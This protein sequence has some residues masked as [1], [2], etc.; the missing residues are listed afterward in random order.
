MGSRGRLLLFLTTVLYLVLTP[1]A[2]PL[3]VDPNPGPLAPLPA[4]GN[5]Q[6]V[7]NVNEFVTV[8][9]PSRVLQRPG[10]GGQ[11]NIRYS[12]NAIRSTSNDVLRSIPVPANDLRAALQAAVNDGAKHSPSEMQTSFVSSAN[13]LSVIMNTYEARSDRPPFNWQD[14]SSV[15][16]VLLKSSPGGAS[17]ANSFV[18]VVV[19]PEGKSIVDFA[20][21]PT[22]V[23]VHSKG[24][25]S[26][27]A[28]APP[29]KY[30]E[31]SLDTPSKLQNRATYL[32]H[33]TAL[34]LEYD[35]GSHG[36]NGLVLRMLIIY[37]MD[38]VLLDVPD[39]TYTTVIASPLGPVQPNEGHV[40]FS[41]RAVN[42]QRISRQDALTIT[43]AIGAVV[44]TYVQWNR[45]PGTPYRSIVGRVLNNDGIGIAYWSVGEP[46]GSV[47]ECGTVIVAQ[48][49]GSRALGCLA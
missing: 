36:V 16:S 47:A 2:N 35:T 42:S 38:M 25:R 29:T 19:N 17:S 49:D 32:I 41:L 21:I 33:N 46:L 31:R 12:V 28:V 9:L 39:Q 15:A 4:P 6:D 11:Y 24:S 8:A 30:A 48:P 27:V 18:G 44:T 40:V 26:L 10:V 5:I 34:S 37:A 20:V 23:H 14:V 3:P 22:F 45:F 13:G 7:V 1:K 43:S